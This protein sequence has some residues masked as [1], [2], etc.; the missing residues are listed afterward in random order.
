MKNEKLYVFL[1]FVNLYMPM[2]IYFCMAINMVVLA[3]HR[4]KTYDF[5]GGKLN[6]I[7]LISFVIFIFSLIAFIGYY[8]AELVVLGKYLRCLLTTVL[9]ISLGSRIVLTE[10]RI[11]KL[12]LG[13]LLVHIV[14]IPIQMAFPS[15]VPP[16]AE[17][18]N[19][20]RDSDIFQRLS[21]RNMG[22]AGS[23]DM[24]AYFS[25]I[26]M[27]L[28]FATFKKTKENKH[29]LIA[30]LFFVSLIRISR[31]GMLVG[32]VF[33]IVCM[34]DDYKYISKASRMFFVAMCI[35][36]L[37]VLSA[38]I[39]PLISSTSDILDNTILYHYEDIDQ[40]NDYGAGSSRAL[41]SEHLSILSH[42]DLYHLMVGGAFSP[43][44]TV[45]KSDIGYVKMICNVGITG[46]FLI[47]LLHLVMYKNLKLYTKK[48]YRQFYYF[49]VVSILVIVIIN[50][51][52][53]LMYSRG[54]YDGLIFMSTVAINSSL[55]FRGQN[56]S[57]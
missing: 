43:N 19:C 28:S 26:G 15:V 18:F 30:L 6:S 9:L 36:F 42:L 11:L 29:L 13:V 4:N 21:I 1:L 10:E 46:L 40:L 2:S 32:V 54:A 33:F 27:A 7:V 5:V 57:I 53:L 47:L 49:L 8:N 38:K 35:A 37:F 56:G 34:I 12:T 48:G 44:T 3:F 14:A 41:L 17:F 16:M 45:Y 31:T 25:I 24:A 23:F 20:D 22:V 51:K 50:Y 39:L 55:Y 52:N